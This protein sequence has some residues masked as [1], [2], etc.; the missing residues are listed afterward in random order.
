MKL[1]KEKLRK[2]KQT[3]FEDISKRKTN[4]LKELKGLHTL[5]SENNISRH[6]LNWIEDVKE[7]IF[8]KEERSWRQKTRL[9]WV[10][11]GDDNTRFYPQVFNGWRRSEIKEL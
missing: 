8:L 7:E 5:T 10:K 9:K 2:W 4:I 3:I 1:L 6:Q 11:E